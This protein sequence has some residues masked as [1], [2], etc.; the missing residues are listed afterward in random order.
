[1][2]VDMAL[3]T[4]LAMGCAVTALAMGCAATALAMGCAATSVPQSR[5]AVSSEA[6]CTS[7]VQATARI[8]CACLHLEPVTAADGT[9]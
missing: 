2:C 5:C 4:A 8:C 7:A 1:M 6:H 3:L 9:F